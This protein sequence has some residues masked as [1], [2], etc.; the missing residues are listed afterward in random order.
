MMSVVSVQ[1]AHFA[2]NEAADDDTP[3]AAAFRRATPRRRRFVI[4]VDTAARMPGNIFPG[5]SVREAA[6]GIEIVG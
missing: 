4:S 3:G 6:R 1:S 2:K 5:G